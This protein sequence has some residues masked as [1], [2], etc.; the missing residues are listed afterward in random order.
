MSKFIKDLNES[1]YLLDHISSFAGMPL[2]PHYLHMNYSHTNFGLLPKE[3]ELNTIPVDQWHTDSVPFV[4]III[5]SDMEGMVGGELQCIRRRG[6][7]AGF[8]LLAATDNNVDSKDLL[9]INY[10]RQGY[11]LFMQGAEIVHHVTPVQKA[12]EPRITVVNS[13]MPKNAFSEDRTVY[14]TFIKDEREAVLEFTRGR[15]WRAKN[16]L[17]ALLKQQKYTEDPKEIATFLNHVISELQMTADLVS[18]KVKDT[19]DF[20]HETEKT[21]E[22]GVER[23]KEI[24]EKKDGSKSEKK[25]TKPKS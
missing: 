1:K 19:M 10:E 12:K 14:Y 17:D 3:G 11:G 8:D 22:S 21:K 24:D 4:L 7:K 16:Q 13:Y 15:V 18:Q 9:N 25:E 20:F 6:R 5:L 2:V 23:K